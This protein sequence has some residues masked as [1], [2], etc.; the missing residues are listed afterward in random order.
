MV[1]PFEWALIVDFKFGHNPP[2][3][4]KENRQLAMEAWAVAT[5]FEC[6]RVDVALVLGFLDSSSTHPY[7]AD[8]FHTIKQ[9]FR[10]VVER[11]LCP[12]AP[13]VVSPQACNY[14]RASLQCPALLSLA[15]ELPLDR[16]PDKVP[17]SELGKLLDY[18]DQIKPWI[19]GVERR[20]YQIAFAG[21]TVP[22]WVRAFGR[23]SRG[24]RAEVT[25]K[26]L[27]DLA[28]KF[29]K[30]PEAVVEKSL[31]SPAAIEKVWGKA[32][33]IRD[34]LEGLIQKKTGKV[35]LV[36]AKEEADA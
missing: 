11:A 35:K 22:G 7:V 19:R 25:E 27:L 8:D 10:R 18:V 20:A 21:G 9:H 15:C 6:P 30:P 23:G 17:P 2:P 31:A 32:K 24:W 1:E 3:P 14:C 16:V 5:G 4:A 28:E 34:A 26:K 36:K 29:G 13:L 12:W 33:A